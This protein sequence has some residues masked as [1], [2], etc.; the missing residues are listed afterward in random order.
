VNNRKWRKRCMIVSSFLSNNTYALPVPRMGTKHPTQVFYVWLVD[1]HTICAKQG[2]ESW[3]SPNKN[4]RIYL[5]DINHS[6]TKNGFWDVNNT[7]WRKWCKFVSPLLFNN[8]FDLPALTIDTKCPNQVLYMLLVDL[9]NIC[10]KQGLERWLS[11]NNDIRICLLDMS[12]IR[13][14]IAFWDGNNRKWRTCCKIVSPFL[15]NN[16][17][18]LPMFT[19]D[20]R[21]SKQLTICAKYGLETRLS[22]NNDIRICFF[23]IKHSWT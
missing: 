19:M 11:P 3:S 20:I 7:K 13:T 8:T 15:Y 1:L 23:D 5:L 21:Y 17:Y 6:K 16:T 22:P 10:A 4:I 12:H 14:K 18:A 9:H 2:L